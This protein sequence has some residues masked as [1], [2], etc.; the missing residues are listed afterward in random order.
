[1]NHQKRN[2]LLVAGVAGAAALAAL[3]LNCDRR[4]DAPVMAQE[5]GAGRQ[6]HWDE[7]KKKNEEAI[8][9]ADEWARPANL[10]PPVN[11]AGWEDSPMLSRDGRTLTFCYFRI[12]PLSLLLE[13][14]ERVPGPLRPGWPTRE[15]FKSR[16][17][18]IYISHLIDGEWTSPAPID[19]PVNSPTGAMGGQWLSADQLRIY[20]NSDGGGRKKGVY[21]SRRKDAASP[22]STPQLLSINSAYLEESPHLSAD[23]TQ[24]YFESTRP[25][26]QG[27]KDIWLSAFSSGQ[28]QQPVNLGPTVNTMENE[29]HPFISA[30]G[31]TLLFMRNQEIYRSRRQTNTWGKPEVIVR[32]GV[33][34]PSLS[35]SGDLCFV[36]VYVSDQKE[37]DCD[38]LIA[39]RKGQK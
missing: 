4:G 23:E 26:G 19:E 32:G 16:S 25:G 10:G 33:G 34:E 12:D 37:Y 36:E 13:K 30:D 20:F 9:I 24:M 11:T 8:W 29:E 1:M 5:T 28:W 3:F 27:K 22:W 31:Q 39:K 2:G 15:P 18:L 14:K 38:I 21:F 35:D 7:L 6:Q 17:A